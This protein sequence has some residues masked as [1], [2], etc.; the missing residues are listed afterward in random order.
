M[1]RI[2]GDS[3][4]G[5]LRASQEA[6]ATA[7]SERMSLQTRLHEIERL[8][9]EA[10][11]RAEDLQRSLTGSET[12]NAARIRQLTNEVSDL[13]QRN[14]TS[15][16]RIGVLE[17]ELQLSQNDAAA[18]LL[19]LQENK[20]ESTAR[21]SELLTK[22]ETIDYELKWSKDEHDVHVA[23]ID[24][25]ERNLQAG[26]DEMAIHLEECTAAQCAAG[27][28]IA[29]LTDLLKGSENTLKESEQQLQTMKDELTKELNEI[30]AAHAAGTLSLFILTIHSPLPYLSQFPVNMSSYQH[31]TATASAFLIRLNL[32]QLWL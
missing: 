1:S 21:I 29:E 23:K 6:L 22:L 28:R 30:K 24:T 31:V 3:L 15:L 11:H 9:R 26:K 19:V 10:A 18:Q 13:M 5:Q 27:A 2:R 12:E 25:L 16:A 8:Q 20:R 17:S 14:A 32:S 4:E 7:E